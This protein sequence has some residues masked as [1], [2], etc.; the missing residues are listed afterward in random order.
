MEWIQKIS[1]HFE[2]T[3]AT[4]RSKLESMKNS[5]VHKIDQEHQTK[6]PANDIT[7]GILTIPFKCQRKKRPKI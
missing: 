4:L 6:G 5:L 1:S 3:H 2:Y 7:N